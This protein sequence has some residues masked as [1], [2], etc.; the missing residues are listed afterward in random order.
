MAS[1]HIEIDGHSTRHNR[2]LRTLVDH[3]QDVQEQV[4][5]IKA[6][7]D[8]LALGADWEALRVAL[9]VETVTDSEDI[10]NLIGSVKTELNATFITQLLG[11]L[12]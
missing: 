10:Y 1:A 11:R 12:G 8:Q 6:T 5:K 2:Q 4:D 3:L 7:Y 9:N